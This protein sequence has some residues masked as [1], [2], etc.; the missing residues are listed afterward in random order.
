MMVPRPLILLLGALNVGGAAIVTTMVEPGN[1]AST[2]LMYIVFVFMALQAAVGVGAIVAGL[3]GPA[4]RLFG[5]RP[6]KQ[7]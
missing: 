1:A 6:G 5:L 4:H 7:G 3:W 2:T